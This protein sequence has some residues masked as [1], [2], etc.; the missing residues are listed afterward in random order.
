MAEVKITEHLSAEIEALRAAGD[1]MNSASET[2]ADDNVNTLKTSVQYIKQHEKMIELFELF[3]KLI[4]KDAQD[5]MA[6]TQIMEE[7]DIAVAAKYN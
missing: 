4:Q 5:L 7:A 6:M 3:Q 2:I 1:S